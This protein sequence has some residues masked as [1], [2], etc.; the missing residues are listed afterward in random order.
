MNTLHLLTVGISATLF[1]AFTT[2]PPSSAIMSKTAESWCI[3][4]SPNELKAG[5]TD[6]DIVIWH[7]RYPQGVFS[8]RDSCETAA[9]NMPPTYNM[10]AKCQSPHPSLVSV[11]VQLPVD[12]LG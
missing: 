10:E 12:T 2:L 11:G 9:V 8:S 7:S 1:I 6:Q 4:L 3:V 5:S